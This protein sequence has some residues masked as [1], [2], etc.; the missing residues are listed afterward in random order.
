[1]ATR[2]GKMEPSCPLG[3][4]RCIPRAKFHQKPYTKSFIDQI[5]SVKI[6]ILLTKREGRT[7]RI[8]ARG[9]DSLWASTSP[10]S[11]ITQKKKELG[12]YPAILTS[13]LVNNPYLMLWPNGVASRRKLKTWVYLNC[14]IC[15][16]QALRALA[17]TCVDLQ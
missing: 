4:T 17:C 12:Q 3:T 7:G 9:L 16:G 5:C 8:S 13:P 15:F 14:D 2:A 6:Y 10:R 1:M 11:I